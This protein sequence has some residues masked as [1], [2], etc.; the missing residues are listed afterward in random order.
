MAVLSE[1]SW[2][3]EWLV[4]SADGD[5]AVLGT[6][7]VVMLLGVVPPIDHSSGVGFDRV[8]RTSRERKSVS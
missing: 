6:D 3:L 7:G 2:G 4:S 5:V 8:P 1:E